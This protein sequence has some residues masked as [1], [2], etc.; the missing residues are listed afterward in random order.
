MRLDLYP[1]ADVEALIARSAKPV[2][3]CVRRARDGGRW[4]GDEA[5]RRKLLHRARAAAYVDVEL[6]AD[7]A[8]APAGPRRIV[9]HHDTERLPDDL[10]AIFER[11]L[12]READVV[13]IAVTPQSAADA[14]RLLD[15][16]TPGLGLGEFGEFTRVLAP[17]TYCA[18]EPVAPGLPAPDVLFDDFKVR[19]IENGFGLYG[20]AGDP[21]GH[22][23]SPA[24]HNAGL[25]RDGIDAAYLRFRV[26]DLSEFWPVFLA[27]GGRGLSVTAPLKVQAAGLATSPDS[28]VVECGAANT[29]LADGRAF[30][31]DVS[32][33]LE[34][35]PPSGGEALVLGAGGTTRAAVCAL[36]RLGYDVAVWARRPDRAAALGH[37][38]AATP[39]S[40]PVLVNTIPLDPPPAPFAYK[41]RGLVRYPA[42][43][44]DHA[45]VAREAASPRAAAHRRRPFPRCAPIWKHTAAPP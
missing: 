27:H 21:I 25:A 9:S 36:N 23:R 31:T 34:L 19:R 33:F 16:P 22:S 41:P 44:Y 39:R 13:K 26:R 18:R 10:D 42:T 5:G 43:G 35:L 2:V 3:A 24:I 29:L 28:D 14:F 8:L 30:N 7:P 12:V 15:L 38:V 32:A 17:W 4:M 1:D 40:A 37:S 11:A 6:D 20:V 45:A